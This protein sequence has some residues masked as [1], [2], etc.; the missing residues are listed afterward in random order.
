MMRVREVVD[1]R[2]L[3]DRSGDGVPLQL[4]PGDDDG[5]VLL[6]VDHAGVG[7]SI[8]MRIEDLRHGLDLVEVSK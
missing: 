8:N 1:R 5:D 6:I 7:I 4:R 2:V 3:V